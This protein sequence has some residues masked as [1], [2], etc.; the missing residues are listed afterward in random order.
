MLRIKD[1]PDAAALIVLMQLQNVNEVSTRNAEE[2]GRSVHINRG[3]LLR[4]FR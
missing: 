4:P 2:H 1:L 3:D